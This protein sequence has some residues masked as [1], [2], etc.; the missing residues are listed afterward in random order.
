MSPYVLAETNPSTSWN[1]LTFIFTLFHLVSKAPA[2]ACVNVF[3][4]F[5]CPANLALINLD[6]LLISAS[7]FFKKGF[8]DL[9]FIFDVTGPKFF[10]I[11]CC[12]CFCGM[13]VYFV[14]CVHFNSISTVQYVSDTLLC[15][16]FYVSLSHRYHV[17]LITSMYFVLYYKYG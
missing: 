10:L 4:N 14:F 5:T 9:Y 15:F 11:D 17:P 12:N 13:F 1:S 6:R 2:I 3:S 7:E 8:S 16:S